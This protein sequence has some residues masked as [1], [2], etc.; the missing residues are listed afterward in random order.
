[1]IKSIGSVAVTVSD[2]EKAAKWY[3]EKLGFEVRGSEGHWITVAPKGCETV[4]H[5]CKTEPLEPGN[6]GIALYATD[7]EATYKELKK[8]GVE[9]SEEL[10]KESWGTYAMLKDPDGNEYWLLQ[11][12]D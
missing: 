3:E 2:G 8:K 10:K 11:S 12:G 5:L 4:I 1:M 7:V 9:F 6:T